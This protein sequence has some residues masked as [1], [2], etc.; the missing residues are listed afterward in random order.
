MDLKV[1]LGTVL[2][3]TTVSTRDIERRE[4]KGREGGK[5]E[6]KEEERARE[7]VG[8]EERE[9]KDQEQAGLNVSAKQR[10]TI[11]IHHQGSSRF[12][13]LIPDAVILSHSSGKVPPPPSHGHHHQSPSQ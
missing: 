5:Q 10:G 13:A 2:D 8:E 11:W 4:R 9:R 1:S 12:W 7:E 3:F 6:R